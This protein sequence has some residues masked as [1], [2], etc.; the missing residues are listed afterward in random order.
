MAPTGPS[1]TEWTKLVQSEYRE[2][3]GLHLTKPQL[4][5]LWGLDQ[6]TCD[7]L[8]ETL[9]QAN[10]LRRTPSEGYVMVDRAH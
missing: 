6:T 5:R 2:M 4:R 9:E 1:I 7:A 8:V 10:F 3:P